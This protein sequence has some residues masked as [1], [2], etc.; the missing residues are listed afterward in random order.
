MLGDDKAG[1]KIKS[2]EQNIDSVTLV[3]DMPPAEGYWRWLIVLI[4]FVAGAANA[5]VVLTWAPIFAQGSTYFTQALGSNNVSTGVNILFSSFQIMY[6][7][8][9]VCAMHVLKRYGLRNTL[10]YGRYVCTM[11]P[12]CVPL[13]CPQTLAR[14]ACVLIAVRTS[15]P[16][17]CK[18]T[19]CIRSHPHPHTHTPPSVS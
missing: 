7:P 9:T 10:L 14:C 4:V 12:L 17:T 15:F 19:C 3:H 18:Y 6:L 16:G 8:G 2:P 13:E 11:Q 1:D 5:M